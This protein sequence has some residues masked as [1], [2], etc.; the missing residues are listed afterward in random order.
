MIVQKGQD[1]LKCKAEGKGLTEATV[2]KKAVFSIDS[3]VRHF[4][5]Q[6]ER[7]LYMVNLRCW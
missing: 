6:E 3:N 4:V 1:A 5:E 7:L 2:G